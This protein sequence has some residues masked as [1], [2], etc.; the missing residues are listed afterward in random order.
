MAR[1]KHVGCG[2]LADFGARGTTKKLHCR[3]HKKPNEVY[4]LI[5]LCN[6][7]GCV[8][9]VC[10]RDKDYCSRHTSQKKKRNC[11]YEGCEKHAWY[12]SINTGLNYCNS[13]KTN[14]SYHLRM[15]KCLSCQNYATFGEPE[16]KKALYCKQHKLDHHINVINAHCIH[17]NAD[18]TLCLTR[19]SFNA[20]GERGARYCSQ[21]KPPSAVL[22]Y[23]KWCGEK[24]CEI[25]PTF[26]ALGSKVLHCSSHR[27]PEEVSAINLRNMRK[28]QKFAIAID[29]AIEAAIAA[30]A[31][32]SAAASTNWMY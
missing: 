31:A 29:A 23:R 8:K 16:T 17:V 32:A 24:G 19:A 4:L 28:A 14:D 18:G 3:K 10:K 27:L 21:H 2:A 15:Q 26:G 9:K 25:L 5:K 6:H 13:H 20:P 7:D 22:S 30:D 12:M 1:C 11:S